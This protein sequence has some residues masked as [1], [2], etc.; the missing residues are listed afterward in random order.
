MCFAGESLAQ[1]LEFLAE[2]I[3]RGSTEEKREALRQIRNLETAEASLKAVPALRDSAEIVRA[4]AAFSVIYLPKDEAFSVLLPLLSDKKEIVRREAAYALGKVRNSS[5]VNP[6][7]QILQKD[8]ITEVRNA[9]VVALGEIG[10]VSAVDA[11]TRILQRR[12]RET[13]EFTRRSAARS[14][15][16]IAQIIQDKAKVL[17][18]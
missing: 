4:T 18:P 10:D 6:L 8:K 15:G 12:P 13:D 16:Q 11:L 9:A 3:T 17:T 2:K 7:L 14:I 5:A 1:N